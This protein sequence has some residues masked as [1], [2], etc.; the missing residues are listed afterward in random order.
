MGNNKN[1]NGRISNTENM[2]LKHERVYRFGSWSRGRTFW[3]P[4]PATQP[5]ISLQNVSRDNRP[6]MTMGPDALLSGCLV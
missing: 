5:P 1:I 6:F 3:P 4:P 2:E